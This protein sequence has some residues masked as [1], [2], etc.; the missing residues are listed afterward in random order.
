MKNDMGHPKL[1]PHVV[2]LVGGHQQIAEKFELHLMEWGIE[3]S[4]H[5][6]Y[7]PLQIGPNTTALVVFK[8]LCSHNLFHAAQLLAVKRNLLLIVVEHNWKKAEP[9]LRKQGL[10]ERVRPSAS[11]LKVGE[12]HAAFTLLSSVKADMERLQKRLDI[13]ESMILEKDAVIEEQQQRLNGI[14]QSITGLDEQQLTHA[15]H[16]DNLS[17]TIARLDEQLLAQATDIASVTNR[18]S[19]PPQTNAD[20]RTAVLL[21]LSNP[22]TALWADRRIAEYVGVSHTLV[23][24][25]R[26]S[27]A[28]GPACKQKG[29]RLSNTGH[30]INT[31]KIGGSEAEPQK[32]RAA[33]SGVYFLP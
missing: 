8:T 4:H 11:T 23:G 27:V 7:P 3:I 18:A 15:T 32:K 20:K 26:M 2:T 25:M 6:K 9:L 24:K 19:G 16:L 29:R 14:L 28:S 30:L 5:Q 31:S 10:L 1:V 22:E 12:E 17:R 33:K 21:V 13:T